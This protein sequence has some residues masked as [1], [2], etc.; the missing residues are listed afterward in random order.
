MPGTMGNPGQYDLFEGDAESRASVEDEDED[1][2]RSLIDTLISNTK[3]YNSA[4]R[5]MKLLQFIA[6]F[7]QFAPFN[8]MLLHIQKPGLTHAATIRDWWKKFHRE[9]KRDA[10]PL[11]ILRPFGPVDFVYDIQETEGDPLPEEA[12][13]FVAHG[14]TPIG[15]FESAIHILDRLNIKISTIDQGDG[16]AGYIQRLNHPDAESPDFYRLCVNQNHST[17][18]RFVTIA[19]ELGHLFFR[20]SGCR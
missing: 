4:E 9:P 12:F 15:W 11:L 16:S 18:T 2:A 1:E 14:Q 13:Q 20:T 6:R 3:L 19:H 5:Q 8:A 17:A 10:R 7:R